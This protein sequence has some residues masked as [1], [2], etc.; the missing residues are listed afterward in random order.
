M[1]KKKRKGVFAR[2]IDKLNMWFA[3][4]AIASFLSVM[5]MI[6]DD[7]ARP[8]KAYQRE[9]RVVQNEVTQQQLTDEQS[10]VDQEEL[11]AIRQRRD[12]AEQELAAR[13][14]RVDELGGEL[15]A[16]QSR[17][18]L[19]DQE[20]RFARSVY[21]TRRW[22]YE[23][24]RK[25]HGDEGSTAERDAFAAAESDLEQFR[26]ELE[27]LT[28]ERD[29]IQTDLD[30][31]SATRDGA[32]SEI[33]GMTREI[34]RLETRLDSLRFSWVYYLRNAPFMDGLN[35]SERI[36]QV[37]LNDV[38]FDLN[39]TDAPRVDRCQTCHLG[40]DSV[41]FEGYA[42]PFASHPRLDMFV[43]D[44][45]PHPAAE[46]GC[47]VC[48]GG[49]GP[50]TTFYTAVH[51]PDN[52]S[53]EERWEHDLGWDH[54]ELWEWPMRSSGDIEA[55]CVKCH[56]D[57]PWLPE[58]PKLEY[59]LELI[60]GLG[61]SGCHQID[62]FDDDRKRGP[63]LSRIASKTDVEWAYNWVMDPKS[64]RPET[65]MP[66]F[67]NLANT[68][69]A[70]WSVRNEVEAEAIVSYLFA[71]S[72][73]IELASA[74][75]GNVM[76]GQELVENVGCLGCH[77]VG[78]FAEE[79]AYDPNTERFSGY[80][81][82]GPNLDGIGSKVSA[83]WLFS[84]VKDP[85]HYWADTNMPNLRLTDGEAND[86]TAY[87]MSLTHDAFESAS[88]PTVDATVRSDVAREYLQQQMP[89]QMA[90]DSLAAMDEDATRQYL[91]ERLIARYG[92]AGCHVVPG[93][94]DAGRIGTSL[95]NWGS[96][97]VGRLDFG[98]LDLEHGRRA[99]LEQKLRAPRSYDDGR[100]RGA[101][102]ILRMP[103][104]DLTTEEID[105]ISV[106]ILGFTDE[107]MLP[108]AKPAETPRRI[109]ILAGQAIAD[110]YN[111]RGCHIL[112]GQGGA[113][114]TVIA[115]GKVASGDVANATAGLAFGPPNLTSEGAR[116]QP[117]WLYRFL[118]DPTTVRPWLDVRMPTFSFTDYELNAL[119]AYFAAVDEAPYP[120]ESTFTTAH[121]YPGDLVSEGA[122]L[123]ADQ[124]GSLQCF[125][126]H[127]R[128]TQEPRVPST[129]WAPDLALAADR[130]RPEWIDGWIKD[131]Q[132]LQ[133]GTNM[134]QFYMSMEP[135][136]GFWAPLNNDPQT[137]IDALVA[138]I[139]SLGN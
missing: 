29:A 66:R 136:R 77:M 48:H 109:A 86:V 105:A 50:A 3:I 107:E 36:N 101:Q 90:A 95:S 129:Q 74:S 124:R 44:N 134:P 122:E 40:V 6:Y 71:N 62:R 34:D 20:F 58:S 73:T 30:A 45:S 110:Q 17:M 79:E 119:T 125:S 88:I 135:G 120:F 97:A 32:T 137:E 59:G 132:A 8:W 39:F 128:G 98:L 76:R 96:K 46:M 99:F 102:E 67:F 65:P 115:D 5:W 92:C 28:L 54:I 72:S 83:D 106:A 112:Q 130:L 2:D 49:K 35:A 93:F 33:A 75:S 41:D 56:V 126:C 78:D 118:T 53:E 60:E 38:R 113:L 24:A 70:E 47:S 57:D 64:F 61:C 13:G 43:S 116:V 104:F 100:V 108:A 123:A 94:E 42:Q 139:M 12:A 81:H 85:E 87:L 4:I 111:C 18:D 80:R 26:L 51:T 9:F 23:E 22:E 55:S 91:G 11:T 21:D 131:P 114:R 14:D 117:A 69:D 52:E 27:T 121:S 7:Y 19:A 31:M 68:S 84:W 127:F 138:Y 1:A 25:H 103:N 10:N 89:T 37:V 133:P 82:H 16:E 15:A 63:D